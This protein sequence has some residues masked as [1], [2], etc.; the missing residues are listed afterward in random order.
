MRED[1]GPGR[2]RVGVVGAGW[3]AT[4]RHIP[5]FK[6][7]GEATLDAVLD[8]N[9]ARA[10]AVARR[11]RIPR[12]F[13]SLERFLEEPLDAIAVCTP[14]MTHG[15]LIEA[16]LRAGR[17]VLVEKPMTLT[18]GEGR[19]LEALAESSGLVL[20]PAHNFLFSR[21]TARARDVLRRGEVGEVCWAMG[22]Q[23]SSWRRR[24]PTWF[25]QLPGGLFFDEAPHLLYLMRHF[26]GDLD[27]EGAWGTSTGEGPPSGMERLEA[28][29]RGTHGEGYLTMWSGAPFS[30]W[31]FILFCSRGVLVLDLF[32]DLL[33]HLPP[34]KAHSSRDVIEMALRSTYQKWWGMA[35]SGLRFLG[36][37]LYYGHDALVKQFLQSVSGVGEPPATARD[38]WTVVGLMEDI[39][40]LSAGKSRQG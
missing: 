4:K 9:P 28:R 31:L 3:V 20:C 8:P 26:L 6:R 10:E 18:A 21:S 19:A 36:G 27:V 35:T 25:H 7:S 32:R 13:S 37:R 38:G 30:E 12:S 40:K 15:S 34:E 14:P 24:L 33:I 29:L 22:V 17:H 1:A 39:L 2:L 11:F 5:A 16:A 23:L